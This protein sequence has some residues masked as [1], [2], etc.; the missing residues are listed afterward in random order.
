MMISRKNMVKILLGAAIL[1]AGMGMGSITHAQDVNLLWV[2]P[3]KDHPVHRLMQAGFLN[4][5]QELGYYCEVV[6]DPSA[7]NFDISATL[8]LAEAALSRTKFDGVAVHSVDP[9][10]YPYIA[11]LGRE[12]LPVVTWHVLPPE[13]S[14][15][16]LTATASQ[17]IPAAAANA[18]IALGE[19]LGGKGTVALT[20]GASN[21]TENLMS[22]AFRQ[23][24]AEKY[25]DIKVLETQMEGFEPSAAESKAIAILQGNP[26]VVGAFGTTG[27]SP[28]TWAGAARKTGSDIVIIGMDYIRQNLDL[29]KSGDV[30]GLLAQPLYE[31]CAKVAEL[32]GALA[33]GETVPYMNILP[34]KILTA[35]DD[36]DPYYKMLESAGQ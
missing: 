20:Q 9:A 29:V 30:Y 26:D 22:D 7:T 18:A 31:E 16:G 17:E 34:A 11:K 19:K 24:M 35:A 14:V 1:A 10:I 28:Q 5:C 2:Q 8:P 15:P 25:P 36:L 32:L 27:N 3:M 23:T 4:R 6:G 13:G 21:E 12:G 33:K